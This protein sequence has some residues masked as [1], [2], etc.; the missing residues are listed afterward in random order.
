VHKEQRALST[1]AVQDRE[2]SRY[3]L[4]DDQ[5]ILCGRRAGREGK[6]ELVRP[7]ETPHALGFSCIHAVSP[8]I[9]GKMAETGK[10]SIIDAYLRLAGQGEKIESFRADGAYWRDLGRPEAVA[11]AVQDMASGVF[12]AG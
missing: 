11:Q 5:D 8:M 2:T 1:F 3:L 9:F 7:V 6:L 4:F 12:S 10:F